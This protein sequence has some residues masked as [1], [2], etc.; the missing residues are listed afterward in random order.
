[1]ESPHEEM[2][3]LVLVDGSCC[4]VSHSSNDDLWWC[5]NC[6]DLVWIKCQLLSSPMAAAGSYGGA[7]VAATAHRNKFWLRTSRQPLT[8]PWGSWKSSPW[9]ELWHATALLKMLRGSLWETN[10]LRAGKWVIL[11]IVGFIICWR[12]FS[13]VG[14]V[15]LA[16][17]PTTKPPR[18]NHEE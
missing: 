13:T 4:S 6:T 16:E 5:C 3:S 11:D 14:Y 12:W 10:E 15:S 1:V 2:P 8:I 7:E 9:N 18:E 17:G